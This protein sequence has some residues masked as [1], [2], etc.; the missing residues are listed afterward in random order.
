[1]KVGKMEENIVV[2]K[3]WILSAWHKKICETSVF[4]LDGDSLQF[5][6]FEPDKGLSSEE[7]HDYY[8]GSSFGDIDVVELA[9]VSGNLE[10][11][12]LEFELRQV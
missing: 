12:P 3:F 2:M 10:A 1:M 8:F 7:L 4:L 11:L 6:G 9:V 5:A